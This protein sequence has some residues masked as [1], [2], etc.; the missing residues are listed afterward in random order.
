[1]TTDHRLKFARLEAGLRQYELAQLCKL[2]EPLLS[3]FETGRQ[4]PS[5][6]IQERIAAALG[7]PR[8]ELF[9]QIGKVRL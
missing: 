5:L 3:K 9:S 1:M 7:V 8:Y 4:I 6:E 2:P